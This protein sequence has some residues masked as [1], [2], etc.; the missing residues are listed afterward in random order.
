MYG[1][2]INNNFGG[3]TLADI[4]TETGTATVIRSIGDE[5]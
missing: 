5:L 1:Q 4:M 2:A 3:L